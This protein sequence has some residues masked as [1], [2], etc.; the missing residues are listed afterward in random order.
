VDLSMVG[1]YHVHYDCVNEMGAKASTRTRTIVVAP[2]KVPTPA[3]TTAPTLAPTPVWDRGHLYG[4]RK[5]GWMFMPTP[6]PKTFVHSS[7]GGRR[8]KC[9]ANPYW[10]TPAGKLE[11]RTGLPG[12]PGF[13]QRQARKT[14]KG[15]KQQQQ[16]QQQQPTVVSATELNEGANLVEE[17]AAGGIAKGSGVDVDFEERCAQL[18][19]T[20]CQSTTVQTTQGRDVHQC[21]PI[22]DCPV[23][24]EQRW[25][26]SEIATRLYCEDGGHKC[27]NFEELYTGFTCSLCPAG[28]YTR[29]VDVPACKGMYEVER[30]ANCL[31]AYKSAPNVCAKMHSCKH[32]SCEYFTKRHDVCMAKYV[33]ANSRDKTAHEQYSVDHGFN[34]VFPKQCRAVDAKHMVVHHASRDGT[35]SGELETEAPHGHRCGL[36]NEEDK[37]K[38]QC[39]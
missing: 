14:G 30:T 21:V 17:L 22:V 38:C 31:W 10:S 32:M 6:E 1:V 27:N 25:A 20:L 19:P 37:C 12:F 11:Q 36:D 29:K 18:V 28:Y 5:H 24:F 2:P 13:A 26:K 33:D 16:Q 23:G 34:M 4:K 9:G 15:S 7:A 39:L 8:F 3:P 35:R